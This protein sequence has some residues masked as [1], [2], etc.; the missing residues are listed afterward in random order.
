MTKLQEL[1]EVHNRNRNSYSRCTT[2]RGV[3]YN[4]KEYNK[5]VLSQASRLNKS[6]LV[7]RGVEVVK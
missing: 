4:T 6:N 7:Y 3:K 1:I 5:K 2:Y